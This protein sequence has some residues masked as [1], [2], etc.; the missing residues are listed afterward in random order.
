M[1]LRTPFVGSPSFIRAAIR[2]VWLVLV[3]LLMF[4]ATEL[5]PVAVGARRREPRGVVHR[6]RSRARSRSSRSSSAA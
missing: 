5:R 6:A 3:T 4:P 2:R 1:T